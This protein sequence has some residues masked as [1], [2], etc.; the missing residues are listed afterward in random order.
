MLEGDPPE[1]WGGGVNT[2]ECDGNGHL[3]V[4]F[5]VAKSMEALASLM[6]ILG[7]PGVFA[8]QA[9]AT[10]RVKEQYIRFLR[11][12][13][14]GGSLYA[15]GQVIAVGET[16]ARLLIVTHHLSGDLASAMQITVEHVTPA[17]HRPVPWPADFRRRAE[18]LRA[19]VPAKAAARTLTLHAFE[20]TASRSRAQA[21][22][23]QRIGLTALMDRDCDLFGRMRPEVFIGR[24]GDGMPRLF[25][26]EP[27]NPG[28]GA[29]QLG[30]AVLEYRLVHLRT[31]R[32]GDRIEIRAGVA[33]ITERW[34]R[35]VHWLLNPD[36][37]APW[38]VATSIAVAMDLTTRKMTALSPE[39][40]AAA[41]A[42]V[43][44]GLA[45]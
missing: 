31:P 30:G 7:L 22:G 10:L 43:T 35:V 2:W 26:R 39:E 29:R 19:E 24:I 11:E 45:L 6:A 32:L 44:P 41:Q 13:H 15:T 18:A 37:E 12:A 17:D 36:D 40:L 25:N 20:P 21:I 42:V 4:R 33:E 23:L 28:H 38:G 3:N 34:R 16:D 9:A 8:A 5:H 14:A 27:H 1:I